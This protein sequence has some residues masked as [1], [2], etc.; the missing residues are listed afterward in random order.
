M[1]QIIVGALFALIGIGWAVIGFALYGATESP[2]Y[3][4]TIASGFVTAFLGGLMV[5]FGIADRW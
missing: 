3:F 4:I 2:L 1:W 5:G